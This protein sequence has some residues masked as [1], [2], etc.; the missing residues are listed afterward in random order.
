MLANYGSV[1]GTW[2]FAM[3]AILAGVGLVIALFRPKAIAPG[4]ALLAVVGGVLV[5]I[6]FAS[7][8]GWGLRLGFCTPSV[9]V[10]AAGA[11]A[12]V[13]RKSPAAWIAAALMVAVAI[14][15]MVLNLG[16]N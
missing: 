15:L 4:L 13:G 1:L 12:L 16:S 5:T 8:A 2:F 7:Q 14:I 10:V 6:G 3:L 11:I 9:L